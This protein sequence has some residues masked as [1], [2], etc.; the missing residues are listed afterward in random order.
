MV[1]A[2]PSWA[3]THMSSERKE[4]SQMMRKKVSFKSVAPL[5][6][7]AK[8]DWFEVIMRHFASDDKSC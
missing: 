7:M 1:I 6:A 5:T 2:Q 8:R 3:V 4:A